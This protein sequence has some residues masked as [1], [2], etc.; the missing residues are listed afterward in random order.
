ML[1]K[2]RI[3]LC[4]LVGVL[5]VELDTVLAAKNV[6]AADPKKV[7]ADFKFQGEYAG[8]LGGQYDVGAQVI[9]LGGGKYKMVLFPGGLPGAGYDG[10]EKREYMGSRDGN[11][12]NFEGGTTTKSISEKKLTFGRDGQSFSIDRVIRKSPTIGAK[13]PEGAIVLFDGKSA[14][15]FK[16]GK[17]TEGGLLMEGANSIEKFQSH[18]LHLEFRLPYEPTRR[19]QGRAN[20][21]CYLQARYEVQ[22]LDSFG[23][24]GKHNECGGIYTIKD[25]DVN[26]CFPPLQWQTYDID[27]TAAKFDKEGKKTAN[28]RITVRHNGVL[29]HENVELPKRTT[30]SPLAEGPTPGFLHLQDH[31]NPVRYRNIWA[32]KK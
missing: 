23:L 29:I 24:A 18:R 10:A 22:V 16:P 11:T 7:D 14:K 31:S 21:G 4:L 6:D 20:S 26:M 30:A 8:S 19:G 5:S 1:K 13:P 28:A 9:A 27:F 15:N 32:V 2:S 12:V 25:P 17:M 3:I